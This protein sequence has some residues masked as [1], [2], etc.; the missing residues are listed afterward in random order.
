M[1]GQG[2]DLAEVIQAIPPATLDYGDWV[3]IGMALHH[4]GYAFE[5]WDAWSRQDAKRYKGNGAMERKWQGFG[6]SSNP[7]KGGTIVEM[8]RSYGWEPAFWSDSGHAL[9]WDTTEVADT[10]IVDVAWVEPSEIKEPERWSPSQQVIEY[11]EAVFSPE[12]IVGYVTESYE[13]DGR[14]VPA[15]KGD[16]TRTAGELIEAVTKHGDELDASLGAYNPEAGAWVRF[17]PLDGQGVRNDNVAE[18]KHALVESDNM[19]LEKQ[20]A[21]I[22]EL[23]LPVAVLVHSGGKSLHAI[24]RVDAKDYNEYRKRVD[25]LYSVC[26]KNGLDIDTQNKNPSR[27]S[28]LPGCER[29]GRKQFIVAKGIG[30]ES[31]TEWQDWMEE[32]N[33]GLP[34]IIEGEDLDAAEVEEEYPE[35][36]IEDILYP[37]DKMMIAGRSKAGKS[38]A[39]IELC[40]AVA[41]GA[42]WLGKRCR[43]GK[44]LYINLELKQRDRRKRFK[45][46]RDALGIP[47]AAVEG[48]VHYLDLRGKSAPL[49]QLSNSIIRRA[50]KNAYDIIIID[51]I[52]KVISG[53][54]NS[55]EHVSKFCN[56]L[57]RLAETLDCAVVYCHHHSKGSQ[58]QKASMDRASGSGVFGRD[59]DA[60]LDMI[61]LEQSESL[62][63]QQESEMLAKACADFLDAHADKTEGWRDVISQDNQLV[64]EWMLADSKAFVSPLGLESDLLSCAYDARKRSARKSAWRIEAT[65]R[66]FAP[67]T[68]INLWFDWPLH[69]I[70]ESGVLAD[71]KL[72]DERKRGDRGGGDKR[73]EKAKR[74]Q[75]E[76]LRLLREALKA[77]RDDGVAATRDNVQERIGEFEGKAPSKG[78]IESWTKKTKSPWTTI[79]I[80]ESKPGSILCDTSTT[81][82]QG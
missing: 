61:E 62:Q 18:F 48:G 50:A 79:V 78:Q 64:G 9:D 60:L 55:A 46:V 41:A 81:D 37:G 35:P 52:Y 17:N 1:E 28:R 39:L 33:D 66:E 30:R 57:D 74:D 67:L 31:W 82:T 23:E 73:K 65:L 4:E 14:Y 49:E 13:K 21:I 10:R 45:L 44:V 2:Y 29:R 59:A 34:D 75:E 25:Y 36:L 68:P 3:E 53:D 38:F 54:E 6:S 32:L 27:L 63:I 7:V 42:R 8:A 58:G 15:R 51:P 12:Q 26:R 72:D 47:A 40:C 43:R 5:V 56:Q 16:H 19:D 20:K 76:K 77:C 24:V 71:I 70:D 22:E 69:T 11:L 80:D